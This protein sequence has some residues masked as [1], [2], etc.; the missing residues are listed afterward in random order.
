MEHMG[1]DGWCYTVHADHTTLAVVTDR[2]TV[3][4]DANNNSHH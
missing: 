2:T 1:R 4:L 3:K